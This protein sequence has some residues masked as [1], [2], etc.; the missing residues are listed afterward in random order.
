MINK[1][2]KRSKKP[3]YSCEWNPTEGH[4]DIFSRH[5]TGT[6]VCIGSG[7]HESH[8]KNYVESL[9]KNVTG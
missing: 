1:L 5:H 3:Q 6:L 7:T 4:W 2:F 8:T 9:N